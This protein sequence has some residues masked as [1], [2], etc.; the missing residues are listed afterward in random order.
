FERCWQA[1][2]P[3]DL[4]SLIYTSGTTG[5]P[6]GARLT[7]NNF[8]SNASAVPHIVDIIDGDLFLSFLP[9][10][11]VFERMAGH[12]L[13][14]LVGAGIAYAESVFTVQRNMEEVRPTVMASVP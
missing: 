12:Y 1:V 4:A 13:P 2:Q 8:Y 10:S 9:L 6:K 11:H 7:H 14:L 5:E 3:D